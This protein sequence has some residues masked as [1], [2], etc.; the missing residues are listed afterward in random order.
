[1]KIELTFDELRRRL[2]YD[3]GTGIFTWINVSEDIKYLLGTRAGSIRDNGNGKPYRRIELYG[4]AYYASRLAYFYMTGEWPK[5]LVDHINGN[6]IDDRWGNLREASYSENNRNLRPWINK[7]GLP[8]GVSKTRGGRYCAYISECG[9]RKY[10]GI[11]D[12]P[13]EAH[14]LFISERRRVY[15]QFNQF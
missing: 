6:S 4:H 12:T 14:E 3:P 7:S 10:I 5:N 9:K 13:E 1:V 15:G 8:M 2:N 11:K